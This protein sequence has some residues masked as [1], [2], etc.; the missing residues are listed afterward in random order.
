[1]ECQCEFVAV[2]CQ[3]SS[4][5][6]TQAHV[7]GLIQQPSLK[8]I[9]FGRAGETGGFEREEDRRARLESGDEAKQLVEGCVGRAIHVAQ[10]GVVSGVAWRVESCHIGLDEAK[11]GVVGK[12]GV[13]LGPIDGGDLVAAL[14]E[15]GC[16]AAWAGPEF[17]PVCRRCR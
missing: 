14:Q 15:F 16:H 17:E 6:E 10:Q 3:V 5:G 9:D 4:Q 12:A 1:M 11:I 8:S 2:G 7:P 13:Q